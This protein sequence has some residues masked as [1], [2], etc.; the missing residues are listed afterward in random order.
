M[1]NINAKISFVEINDKIHLEE[2][3]TLITLTVNAPTEALFLLKLPLSNKLVCENP[4]ELADN[5]YATLTW[6]ECVNESGMDCFKD[7]RTKPLLLL[8]PLTH[9]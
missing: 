2:I 3:T 6:A 1:C 9:Y 8:S 4:Q 5:H 7:K